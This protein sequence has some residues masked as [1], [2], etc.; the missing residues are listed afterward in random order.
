VALVTIVA[1]CGIEP[2]N[3]RALAWERIAI[4]D[5]RTQIEAVLGPPDAASDTN[6]LGVVQTRLEWID[7]PRRYTATLIADRAVLTEK[8]Q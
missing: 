4:G 6:L 1:G 2:N 7:G 5:S 3:D 8:I